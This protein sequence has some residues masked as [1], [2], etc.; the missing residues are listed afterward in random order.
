ME[1]EKALHRW[2]AFNH[3]LRPDAVERG[4]SAALLT[5]PK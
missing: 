5:R 2:K 3:Q 1:N 4:K